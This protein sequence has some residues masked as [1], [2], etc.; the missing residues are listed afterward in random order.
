M[1]LTGELDALGAISRKPLAGGHARCV[2]RSRSARAA[3]SSN[4][5]AATPGSTF[6]R[7]PSATRSHA[8]RALTPTSP[9]VGTGSH[10]DAIPNAGRFDGTVGVLGGLEAIRALARAGLPPRRSIEL[11]VFTS[12][13]PTRFGIGCVG[14]RLLSGLL[15]PAAAAQLKDREGVSLDEA[16]SAAQVLRRLSSVRLSP[17]HYSAFVELHIE[18][19]PFLE[20]NSYASSAWSLPSPHPPALR[21]P[22]KARAATL[23]PC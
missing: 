17:G 11:V 6:A 23:E 16:R 1:R 5:C 4:A 8:G 13:E 14:S 12:E 18:Q 20:R 9:P 2:H 19:G 7:T 15:D 3:N 22:S 10:I 21:L